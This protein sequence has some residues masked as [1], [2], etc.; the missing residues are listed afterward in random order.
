MI[1]DTMTPVIAATQIEI[2]IAN[3]DT[4]FFKNINPKHKTTHNIAINVPGLAKFPNCTSV[5][6]LTIIP[7]FLNPTKQ[8]KPPRAAEIINLISL[9][10]ASIIIFLIG[11]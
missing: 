7:E 3:E 2:G 8:I 9:G 10:I 5:A 4:L 1:D 6:P 11:V